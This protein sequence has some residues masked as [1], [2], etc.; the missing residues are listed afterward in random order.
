MRDSDEIGDAAFHRLEEELDW[1]EMSNLPRCRA[2][3][4]GLVHPDVP[5]PGVFVRDGAA[6][7]PQGQLDLAVVVS[8]VPEH[9]LEHQ[10]L[11]VVGAG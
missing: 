7:R 11:V 3:R 1:A 6:R 4:S 2:P 9:L 5:W 8:L 10:D